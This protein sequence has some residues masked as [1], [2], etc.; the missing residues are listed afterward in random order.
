V[1][2]FRLLSKKASAE[3]SDWRL[4]DFIYEVATKQ[5]GRS[6][7]LSFDGTGKLL[8]VEQEVD[9]NDI[10]DS[11]K[12][13]RADDVVG[14]TLRI[15]EAIMEGASSTVKTEASDGE[16]LHPARSSGRNSRFAATAELRSQ[17][18]ARSIAEGPSLG[19]T[20][21][22][23]PSVEAGCAPR[24]RRCVHQDHTQG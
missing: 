20:K 24:S 22:S 18:L 12:A 3:R 15:D 5:G 8:E 6:R 2:I 4:T 11:A 7:D 1:K 17:R 23:E 14:D 21:L 13:F 9:V 16:R 10:P 19:T